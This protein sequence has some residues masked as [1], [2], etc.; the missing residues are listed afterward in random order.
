MQTDRQM[1]KQTDVTKIIVTF[2]NYVNAP[3]KD[4]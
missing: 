2:R 4:T 3:K 1:G